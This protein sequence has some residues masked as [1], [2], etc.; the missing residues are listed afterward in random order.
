LLIA[1]RPIRLPYLVIHTQPSGTGDATDVLML[2]E[3]RIFCRITASTLF[4]MTDKDCIVGLL[5]SIAIGFEVA[6]GVAT[7]DLIFMNSSALWS[8]VAREE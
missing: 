5:L 3:A 4:R 6:T 7:L 2:G 8:E 1:P